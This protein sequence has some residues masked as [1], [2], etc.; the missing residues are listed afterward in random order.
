MASEWV[1]TEIRNAR[2]R[3]V[4]EGC[5]VLFPIRMVSF[6]TIRKWKAFDADTGKDMAAEIREYFIPDFR[7]WKDHDKFEEAFARLLND[8]KAAIT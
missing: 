7:E 3:E 4:T 1:K 2:A 6:E 8:L 5:Q